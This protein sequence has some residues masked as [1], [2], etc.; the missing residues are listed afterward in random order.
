[1]AGNSWNQAFLS[2][3]ELSVNIGVLMFVSQLLAL[4]QGSSKTCS[5][6]AESAG[7]SR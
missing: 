3:G 5:L 4:K 1:M 7:S 2:W 6:K